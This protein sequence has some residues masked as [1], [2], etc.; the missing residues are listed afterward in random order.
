MLAIGVTLVSM[1][2][3]RSDRASCDLCRKSFIVRAL[4]TLFVVVHRRCWPASTW[5][6]RARCAYWDSRPSTR[7]PS[8]PAACCRTSVGAGT[9]TSRL[10]ATRYP[11]RRA[12]QRSQCC[13]TQRHCRTAA[14]RPALHT[15]PGHPSLCPPHSALLDKLLYQTPARPRNTTTS[16]SWAST[17]VPPP[18]RHALVH[19]RHVSRPACGRTLLTC[20]SSSSLPG[21]R[22]ATS[23]RRP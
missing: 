21:M 3:P 22:R 14:F 8:R 11:C 15:R 1:R 20:C 10:P 13:E 9:A 5:C 4:R 19:I 18:S 2:L 6:R 16:T 23:A 17:N 7:R 12:R